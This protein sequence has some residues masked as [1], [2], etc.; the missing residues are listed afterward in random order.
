MKKELREKIIAFNKKA[1]EKSEKA[2]DMD[3][4]VKAFSKLPKG[5]LKKILSDG[6]IA[7]LEKYGY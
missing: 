5:Q 6:V 2:S 7:V 4:I 3:T 1:K